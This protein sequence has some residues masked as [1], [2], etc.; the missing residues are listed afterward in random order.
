MS[1]MRRETK[2]PG[3]FAASEAH[4]AELSD[5]LQLQSFLE[6]AEARS[7]AHQRR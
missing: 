7:N 5:A 3:W 2:L 1:D 4:A 6:G